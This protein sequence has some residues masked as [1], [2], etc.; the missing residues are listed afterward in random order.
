MPLLF[1]P[2]NLICEG[3]KR[4]MGILKHDEELVQHIAQ[5]SEI[6]S[7][8]IRQA[9]HDI[10]RFDV[11]VE[12]I[13]MGID[14]ELEKEVHPD[15]YILFISPKDT[16]DLMREYALKLNQFPLISPYTFLSVCG[17]VFVNTYKHRTMSISFGCP[18]SR[19]FGGVKD[20]LV[21]VGLPYYSCLQL[22]G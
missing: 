5:E 14:E 15:M 9:I 17:N 13:L 20:N 21:I 18:E 4:S 19:S 22:F 3:A 1:H 16:M 8:L 11:P 12:N 7:Q 10:P 6:A 2:Q